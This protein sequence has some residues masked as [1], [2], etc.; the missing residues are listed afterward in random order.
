MNLWKRLDFAVILATLVGASFGH[1]DIAVWWL[2]L[3][4]QRYLQIECV[5]RLVHSWCHWFSFWCGYGTGQRMRTIARPDL[6]VVAAADG[7]DG[8]RRRQCRQQNP[9]KFVYN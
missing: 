5:F 2:L 1:M 8:R 7:G 9:G 3:S 6:A 4:S